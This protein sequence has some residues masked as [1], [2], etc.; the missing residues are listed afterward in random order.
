MGASLSLKMPTS[1]YAEELD[2]QLNLEYPDPTCME[3][4]NEI[5]GEKIG[6]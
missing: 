3:D 6:V 5:H 4:G 2:L 1:I